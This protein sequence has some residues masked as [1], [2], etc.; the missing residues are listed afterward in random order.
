MADVI[1]DRWLLDNQSFLQS[2]DFFVEPVTFD[3]KLES[4]L[5]KSFTNIRMF[6]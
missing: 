5:E 3:T 6:C 4:N 1:F 2:S